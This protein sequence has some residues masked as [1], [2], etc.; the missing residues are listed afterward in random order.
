MRRFLFALLL[1]GLAVTV[2][3]QREPLSTDPRADERP[4][5][6]D[7][8]S[9]VIKKKRIRENT[10]FQDKRG[11]FRATGQRTIFYT[12]DGSERYVCL[13]NLSLERILQ[14]MRDDPSRSAWKIGGVFT[15]FN[16]EN[17]ILIQRAVIAP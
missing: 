16:D 11:Y 12:L 2:F 14:A 8:P 5:I 15:E 10:P 4:L 9:S 7:T 3:A 6:V 17:Y 13:E 1:F